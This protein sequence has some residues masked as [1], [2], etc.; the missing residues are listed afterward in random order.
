MT[1]KYD[2][3][4]NGAPLVLVA[5]VLN[6]HLGHVVRGIL[7]I[8]VKNTIHTIH[9]KLRSSML[10]RYSG[11]RVLGYRG[12]VGP[13]MLLDRCI[14]APYEASQLGSLHTILYEF[15]GVIVSSQPRVPVP[16]ASVPFEINQQIPRNAERLGLEDVG[17]DEHAGCH[18][19]T[20]VDDV[21]QM[22][23]LGRE[24]CLVGFFNKHTQLVASAGAS[25]PQVNANPE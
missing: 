11:S 9:R 18:T 14:I 4:A 24:C 1:I 10:K 13:P 3:L 16:A 20:D 2:A 22:A 23:K 6:L 15:L 7:L 8:V 5:A 12:N 25:W 19:I 17:N 21:V